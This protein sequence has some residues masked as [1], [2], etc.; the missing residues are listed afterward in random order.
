MIRPAVSVFG[1]GPWRIVNK[2]ITSL[3]GLC[4]QLT[5]RFSCLDKGAR[6]IDRIILFVCEINM[7]TASHLR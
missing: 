3:I 2:F 1:L 5:L 4:S 7:Q 6:F